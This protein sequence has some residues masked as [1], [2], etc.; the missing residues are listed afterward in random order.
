M[1]AVLVIKKLSFG[2]GIGFG[3]LEPVYVK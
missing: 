3:S 1:T 2:L